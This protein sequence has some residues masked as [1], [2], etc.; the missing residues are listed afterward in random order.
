MTLSDGKS[1]MDIL[2]RLKDLKDQATT[3]RTH[4]YVAACC[5]AAIKE[6]RALRNG[7]VRCATCGKIR[8]RNCGHCDH[9]WES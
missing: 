6:I 2:E 5:E 7:G 3:E 9:L 8:S 1:T 4:Y